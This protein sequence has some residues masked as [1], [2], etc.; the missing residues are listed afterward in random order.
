MSK[1]ESQANLN[2]LK[3][4]MIL[5]GV[6]LVVIIW[7][8]MSGIGQTGYTFS[9][10]VLGDLHAR[11]GESGLLLSLV[12]LALFLASKYDD[13][14]LKG[15]Q[16]GYAT[17][18][19]VQIGLAHAISSTPGIGMIHVLVAFLMFGHGLMMMPKFK[20]ALAAGLLRER[21]PEG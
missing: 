3:W 9:N 10:W 16:M 15:M 12:A 19:L 11:S 18:W 7:Q 6:S 20:D 21:Q 2:L 13:K 4:S 5:T 8:G 1:N 17:L 14:K